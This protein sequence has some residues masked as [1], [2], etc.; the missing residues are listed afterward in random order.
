MTITISLNGRLGNQLF[1]YAV[2]RNISIKCGYD[3]FIDTAYKTHGQD[4]LLSLFNIVNSGSIDKI[5]HTYNQPFG[6]NYFD[7]MIYTIPDNTILFGHFENIEYF[8]ENIK[9]IQNELTIKDESTNTYIN[10]YI[11]SI[12]QNNSKIVG[13]H[14]RRG[15]LI[16]QVSNIEEF[17]NI[18][19]FNN[20]VKQ[21]VD[22]SLATLIKTESNI[23]VLIFTGGIRK[24]GYDTSWINITHDDDLSWVKQ[25]ITERETNYT[26]HISPGSLINDEL[27]DFG[28]LSKCDYIITPYQS[29]FSFMAYCASKNNI[30]LFTRTNLY[31]MK[32]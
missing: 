30:K 8:K 5:E 31:G 18:D 24:L 16:Q 10:S 29:T 13:I 6:S 14:F 20:T 21:F 26:M 22:D 15:D 9:V 12:K 1:Q 2:L 7:R 3:I 25:F 4:N 11:N 32:D 28:L 23:Q 27:I 19:E 17:N